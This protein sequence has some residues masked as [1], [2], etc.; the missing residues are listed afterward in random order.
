[1]ADFDTT[2]VLATVVVAVLAL[3]F[4]SYFFG[5][6]E[7]PKQQKQ[8][9][10]KEK[11]AAAK[12]PS[13]AAAAV[14][15]VSAP[16]APA[17]IATS[18]APKSETPASSDE[19]KAKTKEDKRKAQ[20]LV[21][22]QAKTQAKKEA[23]KKKKAQH[24]KQPVIALSET[25]DDVESE[26]ENE[27]EEEEVNV[28]AQKNSNS[29]SAPAPKKVANDNAASFAT[30][31]DHSNAND[32]WNVVEKNPIKQQ[33]KEKKVKKESS[34]VQEAA[35]VT[36]TATAPSQPMSHAQEKKAASGS[37]SS[38]NTEEATVTVVEAPAP[39]V[40]PEII[41]TIAVDP[42]RFGIVI[43]SK[44]VNKIGIQD[45][46]N[47][48]IRLPRNGEFD[49]DAGEVDV[50][51]IGTDE[52]EVNTAIRAV[53]DLA[54]K[55]YSQLLEGENF[56]EGSITVHPSFLREIIGVGGC[57]LKAIQS[58]YSVRLNTPN[59]AR[60][61]TDTSCKIMV[62]GDREKVKKAK[63]LIKE[64]IRYHHTTI[65]HPGVAHLEM[66]IDPALH[67]HVIGAK[68]S[69]IKHIQQN[70]K[71]H[72]YIPNDHSLHTD[73]LVVGVAEDAQ[74]AEAYIL[75]VIEKATAPKEEKP[76]EFEIKEARRAEEDAA[77]LEPWM[78]TYVRD[79]ALEQQHSLV[80]DS[81]IFNVTDTAAFPTL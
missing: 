29:S 67:K 43:G 39:I 62:V 25:V 24:A 26:S 41:K 3:V 34:V 58:N 42:S 23:Q 13:T 51:V 71:V 64:L 30:S 52:R 10:K 28:V 22:R 6:K 15:P 77:D 61:S 32:G 2:T 81:G 35:A 40:L 16:A 18:K 79:T 72:V 8:A 21:K 69:E 76:S 63:E 65:T 12:A 5:R 47:T 37:S 7:E 45:A 27:D 55:G 75:K 78:Q 9:E 68:G 31:I 70:F 48:E 57:T 73:V 20:D 38:S 33:K 4:G 50:Q 59:V 66:T 54:V 60:G 19:V 1:M 53:K 44:G 46:T 36:A 56:T 74:R 17:P 14:V 80:R 49:A 11:V